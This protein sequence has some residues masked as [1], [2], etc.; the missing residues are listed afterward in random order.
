MNYKISIL[1]PTH[2]RAA[3]LQRL[4]E[5][6]KSQNYKN[7]EWIIVNDGSHDNTDDIVG[8][9]IREGIIEVKYYKKPNGGKASAHNVAV[10]MAQSDLC[11]ICD[12]D[13][14]LTK[15]ALGIIN[16][17][18]NK[19]QSNLVG[20]MIAYRGEKEN[21]TIR[22]KKFATNKVVGSLQEALGNEIFDTTQIYRTKILKEN[23]F[24]ITDG[25]KFF[26]EIWLWKKIDKEYELI[27][28]PEILEICEYQEDGLTKSRKETVWNNPISYSHYF[29][30]EYEL[31]KGIK[32]I[33]NYGIYRGL[34]NI[35]KRCRL[36]KAPFFISLLAIP[37][38]VAVQVKAK[39]ILR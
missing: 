25:E 18:W 16:E 2:N 28:I 38:T 34:V 15:N 13:D 23:L 37:V 35:S 4:Y 30:Q 39:I 31:S 10:G 32:K 7:F 1:T 26:P 12:D 20:G 9:F 11:V 33:K 14:Y 36:K 8:K 21:I 19:Y 24:P 27:I 3:L 29:F 6:I 17:Y 22:K 5:S